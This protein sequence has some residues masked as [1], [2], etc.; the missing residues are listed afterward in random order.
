MAVVQITE[1]EAGVNKFLDRAR[2]ESKMALLTHSIEGCGPCIQLGKLLKQ[3]AVDF[4]DTVLFG[5]MMVEDTPEN[6]AYAEVRDFEGYPWV[7]LYDAT[8]KLVCDDM[9]IDT[10][11]KMK[12]QLHLNMS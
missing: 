4:E 12:L 7:Y 6:E 8:G 9:P 11:I 1:G 5:K 10:S 2:E 3:L